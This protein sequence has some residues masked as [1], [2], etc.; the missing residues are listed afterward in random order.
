M[1]TCK[2]CKKELP[3][4]R[5]YKSSGFCKSC[6]NNILVDE[7]EKKDL[8]NTRY[9]IYWLMIATGIGALFATLYVYFDMQSSPHAEPWMLPFAIFSVLGFV[10]AALL[11]I[12]ILKVR[13]IKSFVRG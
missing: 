5:N 2:I 9:A 6:M 11:A 3:K 10:G 7:L 8:D 4:K 12:Y 1:F 13:K